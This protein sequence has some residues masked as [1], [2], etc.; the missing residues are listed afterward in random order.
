ML[1][2]VLAQCK[3]KRAIYFLLILGLVIPGLTGCWGTPLIDVIIE[4]QT[5]QTLTVFWHSYYEVTSSYLIGEV[6]PGE[7]I[8]SKQHPLHDTYHF[9]AKNTLGETVFSETYTLDAENKYHLVKTDEKHA[10]VVGVYKAVIPPLENGSA[11]SDNITTDNVTT[12]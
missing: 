2:Q 12:K 1:T 8:V 6:M 11:S 7:Q 3:L 5:S 9:S 10:G 4:N